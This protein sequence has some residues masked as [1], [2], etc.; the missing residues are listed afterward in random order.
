MADQFNLCQEPTST[1]INSNPI[2]TNPIRNTSVFQ[3]QRP[4]TFQ[5]TRES[6]Q[7]RT[8]Y[9]F[10]PEKTECPV[11]LSYS[12]LSENDEVSSGELQ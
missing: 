4:S 8:I 1:R 7:D 9:R 3:L 10:V 5:Y 12:P 6:P 2:E 11:L